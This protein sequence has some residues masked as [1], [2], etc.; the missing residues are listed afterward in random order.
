MPAVQFN[1]VGRR[2]KL[3][4]R[5]HALARGVALIGWTFDPLQSR[6]A[7]L[8]LVKLGGVVRR[9]YVNYYGNASTSALHR[10]LDTDRL[11]VEWWVG[12]DRVSRALE[13]DTG[14]GAPAAVVEVP[15]EIE[16]IKA[17]SLEDA[18]AWQ[19]A[20]RAAFQQHLSA[21]LYCAGFQPGEGDA[22]SRY[23]FYPDNHEEGKLVYE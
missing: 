15:R 20:V 1:L 16:Q 12:A 19:Q 18:V 4:Q 17:R 13:D 7:Y 21:G 9:Y 11:F 5:D 10:G 3:A 2:L 14:S 8:N 22:P 6:N 23:L